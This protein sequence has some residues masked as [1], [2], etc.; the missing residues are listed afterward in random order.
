MIDS[1]QASPATLNNLIIK[2]EQAGFCFASGELMRGLLEA[3]NPLALNDWDNFAASWN[4]MPLDQYMA[5][6]GRYRRRRYATLS[7]SADGAIKLEPHQPHYQSLEYNTLNGGVEREFAPIA[8]KALCG[9]TMTSILEF[10][11]T[12]FSQMLPETAWHIELHQFRI[13][14]GHSL[15]GKP[16]PEGV[17]RDGVDFVLVMMV[18]R[19]NI[20]SGTTTMHDLEQRKLD[21]F[22]LTTPLDCAIVNDKRCMHGVTEVQQLDS[23]QVAYRDVLVVTFRSLE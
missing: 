23:N 2:I 22:T 15:A 3:I 16:T 5:D 11:H 12:V 18:R 6:G 21:S 10:C 13:E 14:A 9:N 19:V 8:D 20:S 4:D 17:H 1:E 7:A